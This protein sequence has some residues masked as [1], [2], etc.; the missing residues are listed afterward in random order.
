MECHQKAL[1][2]CSNCVHVLFAA[3]EPVHTVKCCVKLEGEL[4]GEKEEKEAN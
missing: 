3:F 1:K 4:E 2:I